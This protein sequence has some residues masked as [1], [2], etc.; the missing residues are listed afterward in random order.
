MDNAITSARARRAAVLPRRADCVLNYSR[1]F[2]WKIVFL[3]PDIALQGSLPFSSFLSSMLSLFAL[4]SAEV[5]FCFM[6]VMVHALRA[7][8]AFE[9]F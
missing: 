7:R 9:S 3:W 5:A 2:A 1:P 4:S 8:P 6:R